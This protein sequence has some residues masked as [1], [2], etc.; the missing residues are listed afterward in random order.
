[1]FKLNATTS[2]VLILILVIYA[3]IW[4]QTGKQS[5][6]L[7]VRPNKSANKELSISI[8]ETRNH[9]ETS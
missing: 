8:V 3:D 6:R 1:M 7:L 5:L 4:L 2:N 9:V